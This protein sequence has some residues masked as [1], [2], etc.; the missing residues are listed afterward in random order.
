M[1]WW[2]NSDQNELMADLAEMPPETKCWCGWYALGECPQCPAG[3][4]AADKVKVWCQDCH[5]APDPNGGA[6]SHRIG[7]ATFTERE[8][9]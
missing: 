1:A 9:K 3:K 7:C 8:A 5:S 6:I 2:A 4:S